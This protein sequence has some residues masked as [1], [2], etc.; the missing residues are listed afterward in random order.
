MCS[1][2]VLLGYFAGQQDFGLIFGAYL[3][4]FLGYVLATFKFRHYWKYWV[5][6]GVLLRLLLLPIFPPLSDDYFRF[7]W[8]A[9]MGQEG[10]SPFS[11]LPVDWMELHG[12]DSPWTELYPDLN[13]QKY[14][15]VY[16]PLLQYVFAIGVYVSP[17]HLLGAVSVMKSI[18]LLFEVGSIGLIYLI[19]K[20]IKLPEWQV[21]LYALNPLVIIEISGNL[22]FEGMMIFFL[23]LS[24]LLLLKNRLVG[25]A[26]TFGFAISAKLLPLM[27]LPLLIKKVGWKS[28]IIFGFI[29][30]L[31]AGVLLLP[32]S[33]NVELAQ[34][35]LSS[36]RLYY[37]SFEFNGG[38]YYIIREIGYL[39]RGYNE[40]AYIGPGM[41]MATLIIILLLSLFQKKHNLKTLPVVFLTALTTYQLLSTTIHPW[42]ITP[43]VA[44]SALTYLRF[45]IV[46]SGLIALTYIN[47]SYSPYRENMWVVAMEFL[48]ILG[49]A[50]Y[51][52]F[53]QN[54]R[55]PV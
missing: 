2:V 16:P 19:L 51:E 27:F 28:A 53:Y 3:L 18:L 37:Q 36:I 39:A 1:G 9:Y 38:I 35:F 45:P 49:L 14:H 41:A 23:L 31:V 43:L 7:V 50:G 44:L 22:H 20:K 29:S 34:N 40:I 33:G 15:S 47:Y 8:D 55:R 6:F 32:V 42:Y 12:K 30:V 52:L 54:L 21:I 26:A 48:I 46:W 24:I 17:D 11:V 25:A 4:M 10:V 13:S 5:V